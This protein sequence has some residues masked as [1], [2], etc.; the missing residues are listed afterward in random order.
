MK[1]RLDRYSINRPRSRC[2]H[3]YSK[4]KK[5]ISTMILIYVKQ[6]LGNVSSS[7]HEKIKQHWRWVEKSVAY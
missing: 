1:N 6:H 3:T 5:C 7:I 4:Y 2:E